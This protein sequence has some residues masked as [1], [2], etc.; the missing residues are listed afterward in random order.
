MTTR[1][2]RNKGEQF[3][4]AN[5][6]MLAGAKLYYYVANTNTAQDTYSEQGGIVSNQNPITLDASGRLLTPIYVSSDN[7]Y[8]EL[9][10]TSVGVTVSPWPF[11]NIPKAVEAASAATG[12]ERLYLPFV[13]VSS[14]SSPVTLIVADA[15]TGYAVDATSGA[16]NLLLPHASNML[17]GTGYFFKRVDASAYNV[18]VTPAG[19]D[20]ID[21]VN[22]AITVPPGYNGVYL[23]S[24]GAQWLCYCFHSPF[25]RLVG[26]KQT[27]SATATTA[28]NMNLGWHV[29]LSLA[30]S[31]TTLTFTNWPASGT[32][33]KVLL[34]ITNGGAFTIGSAVWP[35]TVVWQEGVAPTITS[36]NGKKDTIMLTSSDG[37]V[38]F[39]GYIIAQDMA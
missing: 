18:T 16:V 23:V 33:A 22:A 26:A 21:G 28:I 35:G 6:R 4:D 32:A 3:F 7:D 36:G 34:E 15:G 31:I 39:R 9:L 20:T 29:L 30:A 1:L 12:F 37:G 5:G 14:T 11:D 2:H 13:Q 17:A 19:S 8:K 25:A 38:N 27:V 24:D 10:V